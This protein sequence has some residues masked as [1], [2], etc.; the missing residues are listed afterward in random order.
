MNGN[1]VTV[2]IVA[3]PPPDL[4]ITSTDIPSQGIAGQPLKVKYSVSNIGTGTTNPNTWND[5]VYL[6]TNQTNNTD[7]QLLGTKNKT[8]GLMLALLH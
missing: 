7:G 1:P 4:I 2:H 8:G 5:V 6:S 3:T